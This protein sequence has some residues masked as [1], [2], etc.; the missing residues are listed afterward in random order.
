MELN[1]MFEILE[2]KFEEKVNTIKSQELLIDSLRREKSVLNNQMA[3]QKGQII[4]LEAKWN[5]IQ[6]LLK[7]VNK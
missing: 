5:K 7:G 1:E 6:T 3:I 4:E 2:K